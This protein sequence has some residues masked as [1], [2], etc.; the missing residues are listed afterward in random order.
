MKRVLHSATAVKE[1]YEI[2]HLQKVGLKSMEGNVVLFIFFILFKNADL[3]SINI[4]YIIKALSL[5]YHCTI[6]THTLK[7]R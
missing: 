2:R 7:A 3:F 4:Y 6:H 5:N 1:V